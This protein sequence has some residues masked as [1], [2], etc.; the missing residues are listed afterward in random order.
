M[1]PGAFYMAKQPHYMCAAV[2]M[3]WMGISPNVH[4]L[5]CASSYT[6]HMEAAVILPPA[7]FPS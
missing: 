1:V 4:F 6:G 3:K 2:C 5:I 7:A